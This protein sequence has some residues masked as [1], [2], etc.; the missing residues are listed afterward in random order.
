MATSLMITLIGGIAYASTDSAASTFTYVSGNEDSA[1][2]VYTPDTFQKTITLESSEDFWIYGQLASVEEQIVNELKLPLKKDNVVTI[3]LSSGNDTNLS[4]G[5][6]EDKTKA[7]SSSVLMKTGDSVTI[8]APKDGT[9]KVYMKN[10]KNTSSNFGL[11]V[12][13]K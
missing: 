11:T 2:F 1:S 10:N 7:P 8:T 4:V 3:K 12:S 13:Y 6:I 5:I 9:Y